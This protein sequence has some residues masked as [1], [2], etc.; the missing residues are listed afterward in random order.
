MEFGSVRPGRLPRRAMEPIGADA[1]ECGAEVSAAD[2]ERFGASL[3]SEQ[4]AL[5][6]AFSTTDVKFTAWP[7]LVR[8]FP[9]LGWIFAFR[10]GLVEFPLPCARCPTSTRSGSRSTISWRSRLRCR[11]CSSWNSSPFMGAH[12]SS[13]CPRQSARS[14]RF[15]DCNLEG[16]INF[17]RSSTR[18]FV[19]VIFKT[20]LSR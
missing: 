6:T 8:L 14:L 4:R 9:N 15:P 20:Q 12:G 16:V 3:S 2:V 10:S 11:G 13:D 1:V 17:Q 18:S 7:E 5:V 19:V